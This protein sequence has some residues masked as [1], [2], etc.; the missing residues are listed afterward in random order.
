MPDAGR[1][2]GVKSVLTIRAGAAYWPN[3]SEDFR[4]RVEVTGPGFNV[5][6]RMPKFE[7]TKTIEAAKLNPRTLR[8]LGP[9][10]STIPYGAV[11]EKLTLDRDM[12][13]FHYLNEPYEIPYSDIAT[14]LK[15]LD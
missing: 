6:A 7:L 1:C 15:P 2:V 11:L 3:G 10:K 9:I 4:A 14:A 13:Q 8:P 5:L 12:Q